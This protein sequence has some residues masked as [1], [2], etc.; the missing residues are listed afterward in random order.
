MF[1]SIGNP[2]GGGGFFAPG[3]G[4]D[5]AAKAFI[6]PN[7][8]TIKTKNLCTIVFIFIERDDEF[9]FN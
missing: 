1:S 5:G 4:G 9:V 8:A 7:K 3:E 6:T 2:G